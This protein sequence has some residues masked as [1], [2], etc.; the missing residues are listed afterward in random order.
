MFN[1]GFPY[2]LQGFPCICELH[3]KHTKI[4]QVEINFTTISIYNVR[5]SRVSIVQFPSRGPNE[6]KWRKGGFTLLRLYHLRISRFQESNVNLLPIRIRKPARSHWNSDVTMRNL[7]SSFYARV[8]GKDVKDSRLT[9]VEVIRD[10]HVFL[11]GRAVGASSENDR[12]VSAIRRVPFRLDVPA[13]KKKKRKEKN[14]RRK[15]E[16]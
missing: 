7:H 1:H 13:R 12:H 14:A 2:L 15:M 11:V 16:K 6:E 5:K 4:S 10:V 8:V 9:I 3:E